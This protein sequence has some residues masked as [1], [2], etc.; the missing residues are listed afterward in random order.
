MGMG[1]GRRVARHGRRSAVASATCN[2]IWVAWIVGI[3]GSRQVEF[4]NRIKI[5]FLFCFPLKA[6]SLLDEYISCD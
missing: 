5:I 3:V 4:R 2:M 6:R 1:A